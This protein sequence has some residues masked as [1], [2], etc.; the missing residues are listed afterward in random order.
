[1]R[2]APRTLLVLVVAVVG[3]AFQQT[4][5]VPAI[6]TVQ[7]DL[8]ASEEWS[9]WLVTVYLIVATVATPALGRLGDLHGRRRML[10]IG[11][12]VFLAGSVAATFAPNMAVLI[13]CRAV[14]GAGG[15][16]YPLCL[17]LVRE[18]LPDHAVTTG[19][20]LLTASFGAGTGIGFVGGGLL[21]EYAS[22]RWIFAVGAILVAAGALCIHR[23]L[24][25]TD[26]RAQGEFD[27]T[28]TALLTVAVVGLLTALTLGV[29]LGWT[30]P[31][32]LALFVVAAA[33]TAWWLRA[34]RRRQHP[35]ID[36]H[37]L[38]ERPVAIAN[39]ATI[40]LGWAMFSSFLLIP[41]FAQASGR[42]GFG[43]GA[44]AVLVGLVL[45]P[46]AVAQT[47]TSPLAGRLAPRLGAR[48][49]FAAGLVL[50][51]AA[52]CLLC[53]VRT[54]AAWLALV[55]LLLGAG[56]GLALASSSDVVTQGVAGDVAAV[57]SAVNSTV[58]RL[59]GGVGGQVATILLAA[60]VLAPHQPRH[61]AFLVA[62]AVAAGLC[63]L[64]AG[65]VAVE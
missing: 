46:M 29:S 6:A 24:P 21:A 38:R 53:V 42:D 18:H 5:I 56:A 16:V 61:T 7:Q 60:L 41:R 14:Q 33:G 1:M 50:V 28:G 35:L 26:T 47:V 51:S 2:A 49:V 25:D 65:L 57:S 59:A 62:Y 63:L 45:L 8:G 3:F 30:S 32:T 4:G 22:W 64:G 55:V 17:A 31:V 52:L 10:L 37:V 58:R 23:A 40:G 27:G 19:I 12:L 13:C 20:A 54:S 9:A 43:F 36:L 15:A 34:E 44:D 11:L 48:R 39:L